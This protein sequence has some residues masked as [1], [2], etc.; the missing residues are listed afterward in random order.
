MASGERE[1]ALRL[2]TNINIE[3][4]LTA[5]ALGNVQRGRRLL[6][7]FTRLPAN[8]FAHMVLEYDDVVG[9]E[10]LRAGSQ[11]VLDTFDSAVEVIGR[12]HVRREGPLLVVSNHPGLND[13]QALFVHIDRP[14]LRT[15]A[16]ARPFLQALPHT[17]Q[18]LIYID[19]NS[20]S[21]LGTARTSIKHLQRG[22][23][24]LT[25]PGGEIEPDPM[26]RPGAVKS[27]ER[28]STSIDLFARLAPETQIVPTVV[29]G[30]ISKQAL[31]NPLTRIHRHPRDK[32]WLAATLQ[33]LIPA[34]RRVP[35]R[36]V[37]GEPLSATDLV[38]SEATPSTAVR[39]AMRE[40]TARHF[41]FV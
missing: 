9:R 20:G 39:A 27:L 6:R 11:W 28:W 30:V 5:F 3:D 13:A 38:D 31:Q 24:L 19:L 17:S 36:V 8:R 2:L 21:G 10:G 35:I 7:A 4:L 33:V 37:F 26:V 18:H 12:E 41:E 32:E 29:G 22:G 14:D 25:F 15:I 40:L 34:Y 1:Q 16:A 23:A